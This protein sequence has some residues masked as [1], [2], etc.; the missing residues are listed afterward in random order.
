MRK[1]VVYF[2]SFNP[3]TNAH[4]AAIKAAKN[5]IN[6]DLGLFVATNG[7]YLR[8]KNNK[9]DDF[10]YLTEEE[11]Q[12]AISKTCN[13]ESDLLFWGF[14]LGGAS[15]D[16]YKTL[17]KIMKEYPDTEIFEVEGADKIYSLPKLNNAEEYV[18]HIHFLIIGRDDIDVRAFIDNDPLLGRYKG[19]FTVLSPIS[20]YSDVSS[21]EVRNLFYAGED[22]ASLIPKASAD[23]LGR[24]K[25]EDFEVSFEDKV[26]FTMQYG[27]RFGG[28][29]AR[30]AVYQENLRIFLDWKNGISDGID[31]GDYTEF[32]NNTKL[33]K[34]KTDVTDIGTLYEHTETGC[35]NIDCVDLAEALIAKGYKPAILN[36]ASAHRPAGGYDRGASAQ[37]ESLCQSSNLSLSLYQYGNP[38]ILKCIRDSKVPDKTIGY[39]FDIN[40]G[41]IYTPDV[42][43]FRQGRAKYYAR[44]ENPFRCAVI[45]VAALSFSGNHLYSD[46]AEHRFNDGNGSFTEAGNEVMLNK[47]RTIF[48][49]GIEH[50]HDSLVLGAFGCGV[51]KLPIPEVV[52]QF[53]AVMNE[54]EFK[55][56]FR[57]ITFAI[58]EGKRGPIESNG[59]FAEFYHE[60]GL[61]SVN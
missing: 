49:M 3:F 54:P 32:L 60:F 42:T 21:T 45:S 41:G 46:E 23:I 38:D 17:C 55:N 6:A 26:K 56:K 29:E 12:E 31:F 4:I 10:F 43:F 37:E 11:R 33:Y 40:Y 22:Y 18:S 7:K 51:Y 15:P 35:A 1:I 9:R 36:L 47:I 34:C 13:E 24:H 20:N 61:Y 19:S 48:R 52:R 25:P 59:K 53:R 27:G 57:L 5:A 44:R 8:R 16:R 58:L 50:G 30:K 2:G 14:E 28:N 39:P